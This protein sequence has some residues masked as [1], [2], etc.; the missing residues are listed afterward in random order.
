MVS[1]PT[2]RFLILSQGWAEALVRTLVCTF[3]RAPD[4]VLG[5]NTVAHG[6]QAWGGHCT[7]ASNPARGETEPAKISPTVRGQA[8]VPN[9][10]FTAQ[11]TWFWKGDR[12]QDRALKGDLADLGT[13]DHRLALS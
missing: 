10:I 13:W 6:T 4:P 1:R 2:Y 8:V 3:P 11:T 12:S 7:T 9:A 5:W